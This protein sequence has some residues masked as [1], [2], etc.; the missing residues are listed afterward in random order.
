MRRREIFDEF[1][2]R[3]LCRSNVFHS[4]KEYTEHLFGSSSIFFEA[5]FM[6]KCT[7]MN[8]L[9]TLGLTT[10]LLLLASTAFSEEPAPPKF[11]DVS[12]RPPKVP[13]PVTATVKDV[14]A[15][16]ILKIEN[17]TS[18]RLLGIEPSHKIEVRRKAM[19][20]LVTEI[21]GKTIHLEYDK[22]LKDELGRLLVYVFVVEKNGA[23][24]KDPIQEDLIW[25]GYAYASSKYPCKKLRRFR[26]YEKGAKKERNG[27]WEGL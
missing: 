6:L 10:V 19:D 18:I 12:H 14:A 21:K 9:K 27:L 23:Q 2:N 16:N 11:F 8:R 13:P 5:Q 4:E 26:I 15:V 17:G 3:F 1:Q 24:A 7:P 22:K 25:R 20:Y